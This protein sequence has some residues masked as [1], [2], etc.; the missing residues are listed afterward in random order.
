MTRLRELLAADLQAMAPGSGWFSGLARCV[1][2]PRFRLVLAHRVGHA[3]ASAGLM[4]VTH[5]VRA[6][7]AGSAVDVH[8]VAVFGPGLCIMHSPGIVVGPQVRVGA[9]ATIYQGVTL[10]DGPRPGQPTIGDDVLIGA[11]AVVLGGVSVGDG[12][13]IGAGAV[14]V[15][16]VPAGATFVGGR[17][18]QVSR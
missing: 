17:A 10:G 16:D 6:V 3:L 4:P 8:P 11:G 15:D 12:A 7:L 1:L 5:L 9:R 2:F 18:V 13:R 14:V